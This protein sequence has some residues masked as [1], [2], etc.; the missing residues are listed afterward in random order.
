MIVPQANLGDVQILAPVH[1][2]F[3][4]GHTPLWG[5]RV[6]AETTAA[7][8]D[9]TV[10]P[11]VQS[12]VPA[13]ASISVST[14][15]QV[16]AQAPPQT[17]PLVSAQNQPPAMSQPPASIPTSAPKQVS[18]A[19][20][21]PAS[22]PVTAPD[23]AS[24]IGKPHHSVPDLVLAPI[25]V[26]MPVPVKSVAPSFAPAPVAASVQ[27]PVLL[28][29]G[30]Q[31]AVSLPEC[32][33]LVSTQQNLETTYASNTHQPEFSVEVGIKKNFAQFL[34]CNTDLCTYA[35]VKEFTPS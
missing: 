14:T 30:I 3:P 27:A 1:P 17:P 29:A 25:P 33:S 10:A 8:L 31:T 26:T 21:A 2:V 11:T 6:D 16:E 15:V 5:S 4:A 20:P 24:V 12:P 28:P 23:T 13:P 35:N 34:R 32:A 22:A 18:I 9:L 7:G 19:A